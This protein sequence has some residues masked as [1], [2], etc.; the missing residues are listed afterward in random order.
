MVTQ[1]SHTS[2]LLLL[3]VCGDKLK[4]NAPVLNLTG[5]LPALS[6]G[7][8]GLGNSS[9]LQLCIASTG[10]GECRKLRLLRSEQ[11]SSEVLL[12]GAEG[13]GPPGTVVLAGQGQ[14]LGVHVSTTPTAMVGWLLLQCMGSFQGCSVWRKREALSFQWCIK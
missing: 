5:L 10:L 13:P 11:K 1:V 9:Q 3:T 12:L 8:M 6:G 14:T 4:Q 7:R 2:K